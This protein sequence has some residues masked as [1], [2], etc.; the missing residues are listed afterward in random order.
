M[1]SEES[2]RRV[3]M[4]RPAPFRGGDGPDEEPAPR[5]LD[6]AWLRALYL[7]LYG[8]PPYDTERE[9]WR[10]KPLGD[11]IRVA[12]ES[13]EAWRHWLD[14]QL[15]YFMLIDTFRPV[16]TSLDELPALL[17]EGRMAARDALHRIALSTSFDQRNPGADTFVTVVM[18]QFCGIDVQRSQGELKIGKAAYDGGKG[19][20]L[21]SKASSQSDVVRIAA[22]HK[23]AA[24]HLVEREHDRLTRR[25]LD[26][27]QRARTAKSLQ[28]AP[29]GFPGILAGWLESDAYAERVEEGAPMSNRA[30][31]RSVFID[32]GGSL[33]DADDA[34]A[35]RG[36]LDALGDPAPLRSAIVRMLLT[37]EETRPPGAVEY[38]EAWV[39]QA[40]RRLLGRAPTDDETK[41][42][43]GAIRDSVDGPGIVLYTLMTS[44]EYERP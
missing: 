26:K 35:L 18:E 28:R 30:W 39:D 41:A 17:A 13:E 4:N 11:F 2:H 15:Y 19:I 10:G 33:P 29:M 9:Q 22:T 3:L 12:L 7:D 14:E 37:A 20:F 24:K 1:T 6:D 40:F 44:D 32:L 25:P 34:E 36:A 38:P 31:V 43:A 16:G 42:F 27:R 5:R 23:D 8:R 21:G